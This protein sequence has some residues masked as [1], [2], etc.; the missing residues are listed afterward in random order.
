VPQ[1][2]AGDS[3]LCSKYY[4]LVPECIS[5]ESICIAFMRSLEWNWGSKDNEKS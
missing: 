2:V 5:P 1:G 3:E 4:T